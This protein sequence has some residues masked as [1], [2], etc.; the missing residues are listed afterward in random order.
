MTS[1][2][3]YKYNVKFHI[4]PSSFMQLIVISNDHDQSSVTTDPRP[5]GFAI[6]LRNT[7]SL[8]PESKDSENSENNKTSLPQQPFICDHIYNNDARN[9][10]SLQKCKD[11]Y[12][13]ETTLLFEDS[14]I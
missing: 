5:Y 14:K 2:A 7:S 8:W 1:L 6:K 12:P 4:A 9:I 13:P 3:K 10:R 11:S